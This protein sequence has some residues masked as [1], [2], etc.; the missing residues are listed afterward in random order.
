MRRNW[1]KRLAFAC[2]MHIIA[3]SDE[4]YTRRFP[5]AVSSC[6]EVE[7]SKTCLYRNSISAVLAFLLM[8]IVYNFRFELVSKIINS[9]TPGAVRI[10]KLINLFHRT[11]KTELLLSLCK[12][13]M[14]MNFESRMTLNLNMKRQRR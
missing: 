3:A 1:L 6:A 10:P 4:C 9:T 13:V 8:Q 14:R 7:R 5:S 2:S 12:Y 11:V